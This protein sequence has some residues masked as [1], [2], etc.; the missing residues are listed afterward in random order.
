MASVGKGV[1]ASDTHTPPRPASEILPSPTHTSVPGSIMP[2]QPQLRQRTTPPPHRFPDVVKSEP[3][4]PI[5][6]RCSSRADKAVKTGRRFTLTKTERDEQGQWLP[7]MVERF[8]SVLDPL[9]GDPNW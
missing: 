3:I 4:P 2:S 9:L 8:T 5:P 7:E 1:D 6:P